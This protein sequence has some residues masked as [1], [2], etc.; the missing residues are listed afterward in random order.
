MHTLPHLGRHETV[1]PTTPADSLIPALLN[2]TFPTAL[3]DRLQA[4]HR[5]TAALTGRALEEYRRFLV[6]AAT[7][8]IPVTPSRL[9]DEV[10]HLH[11]TFTRDYWER[12][13][14]LLPAPLHHE[15]ANG[16][17]GDAAHYADQYLATL[18]LYAE[19]FGVRPPADLWPDPRRSAPPT[20]APRHW[21]WLMPLAAALVAWATFAWSSF[22]VLIALAVLILVGVALAAQSSTPPQP[23]KRDGDSGSGGAES[24]GADTGSDGSCSDSGG[25]DGG[26]S[27]GGGCGGGC[28]S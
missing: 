24:F 4:E 10:W 9:V 14:P 19:T 6:L 23:R 18:N 7:G 26:S 5:W 28:G 16:Q 11:L 25:S 13:T 12:L 17:P 3:I 1:S 27:C 20:R 15:P 22:A 2:Y 8:G 21:R